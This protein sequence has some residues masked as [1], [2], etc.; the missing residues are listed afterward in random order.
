MIERVFCSV[1]EIPGL[2]HRMEAYIE[3]LPE[4]KRVNLVASIEGE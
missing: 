4:E 1:D 3:M 2:I